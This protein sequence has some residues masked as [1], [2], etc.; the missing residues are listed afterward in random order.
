MIRHV[1]IAALLISSA[2]PALALSCLR[3]DVTRAF[4]QAQESEEKYIVLSGILVFD[5][6]RLPK[7][8]VNNSPPVTRIP[9][10]MTGRALTRTGF[11]FDFD[12]D[13]TL[14][15]LCFGPWCGGAGSDVSY[16]AFLRQEE[17]G[18]VVSADPCASLM[19]QDPGQDVLETVA[20]CFK[21][22]RCPE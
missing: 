17:A 2:A 8:V 13:V 3:P 1:L 15:V 21:A 4:A 16:L 18:Y 10:R 9:A 11:D 19:F 20:A 7:A 6:A 12:R 14:E 5:A 22:G